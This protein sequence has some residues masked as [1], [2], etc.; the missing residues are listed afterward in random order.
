MLLLL[1]LLLLCDGVGNVHGKTI[2]ENS[3]D[4]HALLDFK[5]GIT[6]DPPALS[7]WNTTIHFCRWNGVHCTTTRPFRVLYLILSGQN[8]EG[9]IS[10]SLGNLTFLSYLDL[11]GNSFVGPL[12]SLGNLKQ[13][14]TLYLY[15]N[16]LNGIIPDWLVVT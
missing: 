3:V 16:Q 5:K 6:N 13:L 11:S 1:A 15:K 4:L 2:H 10:S 7:N 9:Q 8:L 12:P 14:Q